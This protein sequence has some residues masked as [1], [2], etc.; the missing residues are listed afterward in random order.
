M[1]ATYS[2]RFI[3]PSSFQTGPTPIFPQSSPGVQSGTC[4]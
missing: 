1:T 2:G 4:P 3:P